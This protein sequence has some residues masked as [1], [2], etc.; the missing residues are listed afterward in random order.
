MKP[1]TLSPTSTDRIISE[2]NPI[3]RNTLMNRSTLGLVLFLNDVIILKEE[4]NPNTIPLTLK[5]TQSIPICTVE[6]FTPVYSV[7][8]P[9]IYPK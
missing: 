4:K 9:N 2:T 5:H 8:V 7:S 6:K 3:P 1:V